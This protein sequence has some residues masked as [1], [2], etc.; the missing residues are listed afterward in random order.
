MRPVLFRW[1]G[2]VIHSYLAMLYLGL[3]TGILAGN[4]AAH[5]AGIDAFR[6]LVATLILLV[7]A[8]IGARLF[9]VASNWRF[10][11][12]RTER[13]WNRNEGGAA[14]YGGL[15]L[16]LPLSFPLLGILHLSWGR[17][18][19]V[20]V[21]TIMVGMIFGRIGCVLN[22]CCAGRASR[23][24]LAVS[25]PN[26]EGV[27]VRRLPTQC[28][29]AGWAAVLLMVAIEVRS[30]LRTPGA[31]FWIVAAGYATG[32]VV[33]E[34]TREPQSGAGRFTIH[35]GVSIAVILLSAVALG[36]S[37]PKS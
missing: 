4:A 37:W 7:P 28:L 23:S 2:V 27:W 18:W 29:E 15:A 6:V 35:H 30:R 16:A 25:L 19:D 8:L 36:F 20:A 11:R 3:V 32:R 9:Y 22:G 17:F 14:Q 5:A 34:S 13:I 10:Y 31:L 33:L 24:W 21:F 12:H 1:R 26:L